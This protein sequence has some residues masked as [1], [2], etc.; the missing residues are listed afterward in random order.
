MCVCHMCVD[1]TGSQKRAADPTGTEL[2]SH[3]GAISTL[4]IEPPLAQKK[5]L[6]CLKDLS[7]DCSVVENTGR[8]LK[9]PKVQILAPTWYF[10]TVYKSDSRD[11]VPFWSPV[12][13]AHR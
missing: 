9:G 3:G 12:A 2:G 7:K 10:T 8:F 1:A 6:Y 13:T 11:P 5:V 4:N